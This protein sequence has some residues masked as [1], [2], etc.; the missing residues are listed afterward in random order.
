MRKLFLCMAAAFLAFACDTDGGGTDTEDY[1]RVTPSTLRASVIGG[2][3]NVIVTSTGNW[4]LTNA[5]AYDW[6][7]PSQTEGEDGD[8]ITFT[9]DA[10][11]GET[12]TA[13][14][15]FKTGTAETVLRV[16]SGSTS[17]EPSEST[18][19]LSSDAEID[20]P[21][22]GGQIV[23][24]V[25]TTYNYR[26]L[27]PNVKFTDGDGWLTYGVTNPDENGENA[28]LYFDLTANDS[29]TDRV[30]EITIL[31]P[32]GESLKVNVKQF[33]KPV[34]QSEKSVCTIDLAGGE[35]TV[36]ITSN[37][38]YTASVS[39]DATSWLS[40]KSKNEK[41]VVLE[42]KSGSDTAEG[43]VTLAHSS[44]LGGEVNYTFKVLRKAPSIIEYVPDWNKQRAWPGDPAWN[45][46]AALGGTSGLQDWTCEALVNMN[47]MKAM[48]SLST[49]FGIEGHFLI[50]YGDSG[51]APNRLQLVMPG[52]SYSAGSTNYFGTAATE[53][54][55][56]T[57]TH[58]AITYSSSS[59]TIT[60]YYDGEQVAQA[61]YYNNYPVKFAYTNH[62][63][64]QGTYI[65]RCFWVSYAYDGNR[66]WPGQM[67]ELRIWNRELSQNEIKADNHFYEVKNPES[68]SSLVAYWRCN[69]NDNSGVFKDYSGNGNDLK[70][71]TSNP[72]TWVPVALGTPSK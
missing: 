8:L 45:N 67:C 10:N 61:S 19:E 65:T 44:T 30:A 18:F 39:D 69:E 31:S 51:V 37:V 20:A 42:V 58:V 15:T 56:N 6:V 23:V 54:K 68:E 27:T 7:T 22:A 17:D 66:F 11:G 71:D 25:S 47:T 52:Y 14:F 34:L 24:E 63:L 70:Y 46:A 2:D 1:I 38:E 43:E 32:E 60:V 41:Q 36:P 40:V 29:A 33:R 49:V 50:R 3:Y 72:F 53:I 62:N 26:K 9:V 55:L 57:W 64:E 48:G 13:E 4:T 5:D 59:K 16:V 21:T 12:R 28:L 35:L